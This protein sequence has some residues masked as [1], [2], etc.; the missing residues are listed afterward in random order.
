MQSSQFEGVNNV[1]RVRP[2]DFVIVRSWAQ[3]LIKWPLIEMETVNYGVFIAS[4][5]NF[6]FYF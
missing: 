1:T 3:Y 5:Q 6:M 2:N 4:W